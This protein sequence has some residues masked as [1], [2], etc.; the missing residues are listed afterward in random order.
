MLLRYTA[1]VCSL[2][3]R[4]PCDPL[5]APAGLPGENRLRVQVRGLS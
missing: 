1:A 2:L 4:C 3:L 5:V